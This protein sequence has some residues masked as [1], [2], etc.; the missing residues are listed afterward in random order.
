M[1]VSTEKLQEA[2]DYIREI[3]S[4]ELSDL[5]WDGKTSNDIAVNISAE[6][7]Q[8]VGLNNVSFAEFNYLV[9]RKALKD[10]V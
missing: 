8:Y 10:E 1:N 9:D 3:N 6:D 2:L 4:H 5:T 7:F